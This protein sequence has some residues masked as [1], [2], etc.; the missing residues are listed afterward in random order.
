LAIA[1][2]SSSSLYGMIE[3]TGPKISSRAMRI[4][5]LTSANTVGR[6]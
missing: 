2:A 1:T 6:T 3:S 4:V 5:G